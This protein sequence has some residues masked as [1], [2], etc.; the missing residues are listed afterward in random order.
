ML[1][2]LLQPNDGSAR[3]LGYDAVKEVAKIRTKVAGGFII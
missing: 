1:A 2:T 3:V